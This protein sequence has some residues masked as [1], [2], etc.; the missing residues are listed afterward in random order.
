MKISIPFWLA[1]RLPF[2][3]S[4]LRG[5]GGAVQ[6]TADPTARFRGGGPSRISLISRISRISLISP[7]SRIPLHVMRIPTYPS[8]PHIP[9]KSIHR[10]LT[11]FS[12]ILLYLRYN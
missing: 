4:A 8:Y 10:P 2:L 9:I 7:Q 12:L 6:K 1:G 3:F 5:L 11:A